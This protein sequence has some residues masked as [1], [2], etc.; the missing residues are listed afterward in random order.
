M[1]TSFVLA[2][3]TLAF[4]RASPTPVD[5]YKVIDAVD[6]NSTAAG[7]NGSPPATTNTP[8]TSHGWKVL[9]DNTTVES[10][11]AAA[12]KSNPTVSASSSL[13]IPSYVVLGVAA[14]YTWMM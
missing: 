12:E 6:K 10:I 3:A 7:P 8:N 2:V 11:R 14:G 1:L 5:N 9:S 4:V 13:Q